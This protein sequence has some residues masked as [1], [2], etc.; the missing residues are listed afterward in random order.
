M[1][2]L[3]GL[4]DFGLGIVVQP[5]REVDDIPGLHFLVV[6]GDKTQAAAGNIYDQAVWYRSI[7][8]D[9]FPA[10]IG[11]VFLGVLFPFQDLVKAGEINSFPIFVP[12]LYL[13][14]KNIVADALDLAAVF[15]A[16]GGN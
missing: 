10:D 16:Q 15:V 2:H 7:D 12:E 4:G 8:M 1:P 14:K 11:P 9:A 13:S 6:Q 5:E 3:A